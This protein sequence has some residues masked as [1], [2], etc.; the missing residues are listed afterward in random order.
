[1]ITFRRMEGTE[2]ERIA[3]IDRSEHVTQYYVYKDGGLERKDVDWQIGGW[4]AG[5]LEE[6]LRAWRPFFD[7]GGIMLGAFDGSALIG[8]AIYRPRLTKDMAQYA[9]LYV[10]SD[11]RGRGVGSELT[12]NVIGLARADGSN[13][14]Y[15]SATPSVATVEFYR[16]HG[17]EVTSE[18][19]PELLE[20]EPEDIHMTMEL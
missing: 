6:N 16:R 14:L 15:V 17:F 10:S 19:N 2:L 3:E 20:L 5:E 7:C 18:A 9:V 4:S 13:K 1:M 11:Y 12:E 8:F